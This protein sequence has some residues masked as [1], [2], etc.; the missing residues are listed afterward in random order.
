MAVAKF[1][2]Q[3]ADYNVFDSYL[4]TIIP[5]FLLSQLFYIR[6]NL[7][8]TRGKFLV[9]IKR[10]LWRFNSLRVVQKIATTLKVCRQ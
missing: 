4:M 2:F 9:E 6:K 7:D 3:C 10:E 1:R 5:L 8:K